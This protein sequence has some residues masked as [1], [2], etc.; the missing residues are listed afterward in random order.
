MKPHVSSIERAFELAGS[1]EVREIAD[2]LRI[3]KTEG[4]NERQIEGRQ[5]RDKLK[6]SI[7]ASQGNVV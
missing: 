4:Y 7:K 2:I 5:L 6:A 1:G 3:L